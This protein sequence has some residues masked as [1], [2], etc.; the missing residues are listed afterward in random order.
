MNFLLPLITVL[1]LTSGG[2]SVKPEIPQAE[3]ETAPRISITLQTVELPLGQDSVILEILTNTQGMPI[4]GFEL[5]IET[6]SPMLEI[7]AISQ[8]EFQDSCRW[9]QFSSRRLNPGE[10]TQRWHLVS[11][12][13]MGSVDSTRCFIPD[14]GMS[15]ARIV[16]KVRTPEIYTDTLHPVYFAWSSCADN[17]F[18]DMT[19]SQ[20]LIGEVVDWSLP[21]PWGQQETLRSYVGPD[22]NCFKRG[23]RPPSNVIEFH[24]GGVILSS[25]IPLPEPTDSTVSDTIPPAGVDDLH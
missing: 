21:A 16:A 23:K 12:A 19:G 4:G 9:E 20:L 14:S 10:L 7:Q 15:L 11:L 1:S 6:A 3:L 5:I 8:G 22:M 25:E 18:S 2:D 13:S 17:S 24:N